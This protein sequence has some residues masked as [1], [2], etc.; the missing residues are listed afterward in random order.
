MSVDVFCCSAF[1]S[2]TSL[3]SHPFSV[4]VTWEVTVKNMILMAVQGKLLL[5]YKIKKFHQTLIY[6]SNIS[7]K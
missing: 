1:G 2:N 3:D 4:Y 7:Y 5:T 6:Q